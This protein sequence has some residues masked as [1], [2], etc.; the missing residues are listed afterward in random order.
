MDSDAWMSRQND[1][2]RHVGRSG[3][4]YNYVKQ[5]LTFNV[6]GDVLYDD[7][8]G[9]DFVVAQRCAW[10]HRR[11]VHVAQRRG[12]AGGGQIGVVRRR[13]RA[14][15]RNSPRVI[16]PLLDSTMESELYG[17]RCGET[18]LIRTVGR[19]AREGLFLRGD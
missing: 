12:P 14:I 4:S 15:V 13:Q 7:R 5:S 3:G 16:E 9:Y 19:P 18:A 11:S 1:P 6:E 8:G 10:S 2:A 17:H